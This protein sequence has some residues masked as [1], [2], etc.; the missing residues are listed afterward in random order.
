MNDEIQ[1]VPSLTLEPFDSKEAPVPAAPEAP[2]AEPAVFNESS[3]T[4]EERK[5]VDDFA[6]KIELGNSDLI[7]QYG[8][9]AQ[10]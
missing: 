5:M 4:P 10:E 6:Q 2:K 1:A 7:L 3:L 9:G 8:A